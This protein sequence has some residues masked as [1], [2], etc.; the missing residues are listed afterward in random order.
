MNM[1]ANILKEFNWVQNLNLILT[2]S[3]PVLKLEIIVTTPFN[4]ATK[5]LP[6]YMAREISEYD[7]S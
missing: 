7:Y 5:K 6:S 2:S 1:L 3:V 4:S